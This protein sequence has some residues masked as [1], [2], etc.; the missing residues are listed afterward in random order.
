MRISLIKISQN[1]QQM[2][3]IKLNGHFNKKNPPKVEYSTVDSC[4]YERVSKYRWSCRVSHGN[5]YAYRMKYFPDTKKMSIIYMARFILKAPKNKQV[6][7]INGNGLD[8]RRKNLRLCTQ[9]ENAKNRKLNKNNTSGYR[10]VYW[11]K[12]SKKYQA[13]I[14]IGNSKLNNLGGYDSPIEASRKYEEESIR[15]YGK[16]KRTCV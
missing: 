12:H 1:N 3:Q 2:K 14:S 13:I 8:N 7:H 6:D 4:D 5:S 16:F 11:H 10:G 9:D 15:L